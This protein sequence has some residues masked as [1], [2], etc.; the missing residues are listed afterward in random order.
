MYGLLV[1]KKYSLSEQSFLL[2]YQNFFLD[3]LQFVRHLILIQ[4]C[5]RTKKLTLFS[6]KR[7][8]VTNASTFSIS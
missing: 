6:Y 3:Y 4:H 7:Q 1:E 5:V 2:M 8:S